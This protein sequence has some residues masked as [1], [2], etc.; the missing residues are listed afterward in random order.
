MRFSIPLTANVPLR[1]FFTGKCIALVDTGA[2]DGVSLTLFGLSQQDAEEF[3][4]VGRNFSLYSPD[5]IFHGAEFTA[6]TNC[7][8]QVIVSNYRVETLDGANLTVT[9]DADQ[10]PLP[11]ETSRGDAPGNP[12][13]VSGLT[14]DTTPAA[15]IVDDAAVAVTSAGAALLAADADRLEV[16]FTNIGSGAVALGAVGITWA[17]RALVLEPG[18]TW[19]ETKAAALVWRAITDAGST[20]SVTMQRLMA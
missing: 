5:R 9:L 10:I 18:D 20:A 16:R 15:S 13:Y 7:T 8:L 14:L 4:E 6:T 2:A 19:V 17:K 3:G 1:Q 12:F 11:V